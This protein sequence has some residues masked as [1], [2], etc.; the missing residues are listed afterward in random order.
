MIRGAPPDGTSIVS[1]GKHREPVPS[2]RFDVPLHAPDVLRPWRRN[3]HVNAA[4]A[5]WRQ[6]RAPRLALVLVVA[7]EMQAVPDDGPPNIVLI[8]W[9]E[10][11][12][13]RAA[14][15]GGVQLVSGNS[16]DAPRSVGARLVIALA[17]MPPSVLRRVEPVDDFEFRDR[18]AAEA[19]L[20]SPMPMCCW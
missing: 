16:R 10:Y 8:C 13:P 4:N 9:F 14:P 1:V 7:E 18:V 15:V 12:T 17:I 5:R 19:R 11:G 3:I 20:V 6:T 2:A